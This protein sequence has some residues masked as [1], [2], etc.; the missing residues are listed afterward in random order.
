MVTTPLV[1]ARRPLCSISSCALW[2]D[3]GAVPSSITAIMTLFMPRAPP[4]TVAFGVKNCYSIFVLECPARYSACPAGVLPADTARDCNSLVA[5]GP[6]GQ[7]AI[8]PCTREASQSIQ[9]A[10]GHL[11]CDKMLPVC[12]FCPAA[13]LHCDVLFSRERFICLMHS[14]AHHYEGSLGVVAIC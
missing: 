12:Y 9:R 8:S 5:A 3:V 1:Q 13:A 4:P 11:R 14:D 7:F 6:A 2:V 10:D